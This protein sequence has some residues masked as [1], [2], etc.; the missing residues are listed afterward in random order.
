[1][2][3]H[4]TGAIAGAASRLAGSETAENCSKW[5]ASRGAVPSVAAKAIATASATGAGTRRRR[6]RALRG[7]VA[8]AIE[9]TAAKLSCQPGSPLARGLSSS[10]AAAA[11]S[12]AYQREA[13]R[14]ASAATVVA[15]PITPARWI[16][17]PAPA[18]GT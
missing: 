9:T 2:P 6:S 17:G 14:P 7:A 8:N 1:M 5:K 12:N 10:V 13:G 11:S 3:S 15:A 18:S 16:D 4:I